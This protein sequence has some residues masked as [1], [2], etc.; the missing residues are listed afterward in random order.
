M[1]KL[2]ST[3]MGGL[4][5]SLLQRNGPGRSAE[6]PVLPG[7]RPTDPLISRRSSSPEPTKRELRQ[8]LRRLGPILRGESVIDLEKLRTECHTAEDAGRLLQAY[9]ISLGEEAKIREIK[10]EA[11]EFIE[12]YFLRNDHLTIPEEIKAAETGVA[13]LILMATL[14]SPDGRDL[15]RQRWAC[16]LLRVMHTIYHMEDDIRFKYIHQIHERIIYKIKEHIHYEGR[17]MFLGNPEKGGIPLVT[18]DVKRLKERES[19]IMKL[20]HKKENIVTEITDVVGIRLVGRTKI[21]ALR[22]L[23]YLV[24]RNLISYPNSIPGQAKNTL[25]PLDQMEKVLDRGDE[26]QLAGYIR[27]IEEGVIVADKEQNDNP[28]SIEYRAINLTYRDKI[29]IENQE[30]LTLAVL[31]EKAQGKYENL[32]ERKRCSDLSP[33]ETCLCEELMAFLEGMIAEIGVTLGRTSRFLNFY[34]PFE[35]QIMDVETYEKNQKSF[36]D[37]KD[38]QRQTAKRRVLRFLC[39]E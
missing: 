31:L 17:E 36:H 10:Q 24:Q 39:D 21:D 34:Y 9:G 4:D 19:I 28:H 5:E 14:P 30:Y 37:Y 6:V 38:K 32:L 11:I 7:A 26:G 3:A 25:I 18:F 2:D 27:L 33:Q 15:L 1:K 20:L 23:N 29:E 12:N 22:I 8:L 16:A 13:D 35:L